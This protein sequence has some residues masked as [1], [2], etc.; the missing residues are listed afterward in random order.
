MCQQIMMSPG[1][2]EL[3]RVSGVWGWLVALPFIFC[4]TLAISQFEHS[5]GVNI[6]LSV[7]A[8]LMICFAAEI[9][10]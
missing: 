3:T 9:D 5:L 1:I 8:A 4:E 2:L 6:D 7:G 10:F